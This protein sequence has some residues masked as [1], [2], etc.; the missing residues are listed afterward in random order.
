MLFRTIFESSIDA[1]R[2]IVDGMT[3][4][5]SDYIA[6]W[7]QIDWREGKE[8]QDVTLAGW[9]V[10]NPHGL[11]PYRTDSGSLSDRTDVEEDDEEES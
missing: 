11:D 9:L 8:Y 3:H 10:P 5:K 4:P 7:Q 2:K 1:A 6:D